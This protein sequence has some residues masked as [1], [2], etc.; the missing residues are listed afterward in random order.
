M[1]C[2]VHE[3]RLDQGLFLSYVWYSYINESHIGLVIFNSIVYEVL[4][5]TNERNALYM[6]LIRM[7]RVMEWK[8][9]QGKFLMVQKNMIRN[10]KLNNQGSKLKITLPVEMLL[11]IISFMWELE[12]VKPQTVTALQK[13]YKPSTSY[14]IMFLMINPFFLMYTSYN[15]FCFCFCRLEEKRLVN[16]WGCFKN[17]FQDATR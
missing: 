17:L 4:R 3:L 6:S 16:E 10:Q 15:N 5:D 13:G 8:I 1:K 12:E 2:L 9:L 14:T 7:L 11:K